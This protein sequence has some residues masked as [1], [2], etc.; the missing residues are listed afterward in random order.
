MQMRVENAIQ[1]LPI[2]I[3]CD[4]EQLACDTM[5]QADL[6]AYNAVSVTS[7]SDAQHLLLKIRPQVIIAFDEANFTLNLLKALTSDFETAVR[8]IVIS[9]S[10]DPS[11]DL[12]S[13]SDHVIPISYLPHIG[14]IIATQMVRIQKAISQQKQFTA[15][16]AHNRQLGQEL[17]VAIQKSAEIALL[18]QTIIHSVSHELRTPM[19]Q[20]K[21]AVALLNEDEH[22]NRTV[23]ELAMEATTRLEGGIRNVTL[24]NELMNET[25]DGQ[26]SSAVPIIQI[27]QAAIRN[28]GR[29]WE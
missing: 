8:P 5:K 6:A 1:D 18:K 14:Q 22:T 21:S 7:V 9:V 27:V 16:E 13:V 3:I 20:V 28:L 29:S 10:D 26:S 4:D 23:V 17:V 15:L 25:S 2:L 11:G 19:L 12:F 24:L